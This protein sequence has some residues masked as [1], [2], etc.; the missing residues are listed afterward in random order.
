MNFAVSA[1][2]LLCAFFAGRWSVVVIKDKNLEAKRYKYLMEARDILDELNDF[3]HD[4]NR[5]KEI[6]DA[7]EER[8]RRS[9]QNAI[10]DISRYQFMDRKSDHWTCMDD[11]YLKS[12]ASAEVNR[13][14][15]E[16]E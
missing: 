1:L 4:L 8:T 10:V 16:E 5:R 12:W 6:L 2:T 3:N 7:Q 15:D 13:F 11:E 14:D 9:Y